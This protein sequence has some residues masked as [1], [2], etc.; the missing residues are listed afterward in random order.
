L[1]FAFDQLGYPFVY[2]L[3]QY[4]SCN[5]FTNEQYQNVIEGPFDN[6]YSEIYGVT[7][8]AWNTAYTN[9]NTGYINP[10]LYKWMFSK[11]K[12]T[13]GAITLLGFDSYGQISGNSVISWT[14]QN[15]NDSVEVWLSRDLENTWIRLGK[16]IASEGSFA[17]DSKLVEDCAFGTIKLLTRNSNGFSNGAT[18]SALQAINNEG[19]SAPF[20]KVSPECYLRMSS[21]LADSIPVKIKVGDAENDSLIIRLFYSTDD[22]NTF[23]EVDKFIIMTSFEY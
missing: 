18:K 19:N 23:A 3:C 5:N 16:K 13:E 6:L 9:P 12:R 21:I 15:P 11:V 7:H 10:Y 17:F 14:A 22:G 2:P 4:S 8:E 1:V 20:L